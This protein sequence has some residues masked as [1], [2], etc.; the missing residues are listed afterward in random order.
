MHSWQHE[1]TFARE[2][3]CLYVRIKSPIKNIFWIS[4]SNVNRRPSR[5]S[6]VARIYPLEGGG[7]P[8]ALLFVG[9]KLSVVHLVHIKHDFVRG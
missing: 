2:N 7:A 9:H 1:F 5:I 6:G 3:I 4:N 8:G